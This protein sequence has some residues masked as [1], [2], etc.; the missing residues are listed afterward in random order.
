MTFPLPRRF[1]RVR[2]FPKRIGIVWFQGEENLTRPSFV[3]NVRN[4]RL[5]NPEW[6][7]VVLDD[8]ALREICYR[9]SEAC[10]RLYDQFDVMHLKIDFG[11]YVSLWETVGMYV[12]MDCFA[13]RSLDRSSHIQSVMQKYEKEGMDIIGLSEF[14]MGTVEGWLGQLAMGNSLSSIVT[15][16]VNNGVMM[17]TP[18]HPLM[19]EWID[20]LICEN[21]PYPPLPP[22]PTPAQK[23]RRIQNTTG[24]TRFNR[25]FQR[26][27]DKECI[28]RLPFYLFE[29]GLPYLH[30]DIREETVAI[31]VMDNSWATP[32]TKSLQKFYYLYV[33]PYLGVFVLFILILLIFRKK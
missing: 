12:D 31:H 25:F 13:M 4:W 3:E 32:T 6:E 7:V 24:P 9:Y 22:S 16:E 18:H 30:Y 10:G 28:V 19:R 17:A 33:R 29:P 1:R 5:L 23:H 8:A 26:H 11:R 21:Q 20:T 2:R 14:P 27:W 15:I